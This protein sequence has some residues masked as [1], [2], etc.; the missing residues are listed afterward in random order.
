M[1]RFSRECGGDMRSFSAGVVF[2]FQTVDNNKKKFISLQLGCSEKICIA[3]PLE[4]VRRI[5]FYIKNSKN[6]SKKK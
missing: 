3:F 2:F 6:C 5:F 1:R 4:L